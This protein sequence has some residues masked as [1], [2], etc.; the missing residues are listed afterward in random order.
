MSER[1]R[2]RISTSGGT[3]ALPFP[4]QG[5]VENIAYEQQ[6]PLTTTDC[7]NVVPFD[8]SED[9]ARGGQRSGVSKYVT[10]AVN[11]T[12]FIQNITQATKVLPSA[13][14]VPS[15]QVY[16]ETFTGTGGGAIDGGAWV[17][18]R[19]T[20]AAGATWPGIT[21]A[22]DPGVG[23]YLFQ[24]ITNRAA[25]DWTDSVAFV[26]VNEGRLLRKIITPTFPRYP[27]D[28]LHKYILKVRILTDGAAA[29]A[30]GESFYKGIVF[31]HKA[32][33]EEYFFVGWRRDAGANTQTLVLLDSAVVP[34]ITPLTSVVLAGAP[35]SAWH[36]LE[37]RVN[38]NYVEVYWDGE[39]KFI[40]SITP[41]THGTLDHKHFGLVDVR[42]HTAGAWVND[43]IGAFDDFQAFE[44]VP[45]PVFREPKLL[46]VSGG[47]AYEGTP[48][49]I[50]CVLDPVSGGS[51]VFVDD[52]RDIGSQFA[53]QRVFF[54]D[55]T[56]TG[57]RAYT[58]ATNTMVTWASLIAVGGGTLPAP[59]SGTDRCR[60]VSLWKG[61]VILFG[62]VSDPH[63]IF[64]SRIGN[65][66][67][68]NFAATDTS[69]AVQ[70][71]A[72][73][74]GLIADVVT[75]VI[76]YRGDTLLIGGDHSIH[77]L[78]G[79]PG[80]RSVATMQILSDKI[81]IAGPRAWAVSKDRT[82]YFWS[83]DGLYALAP[84]QMNVDRT[85]RLSAGRL[86][87][88]FSDID[89]A[90]NRVT[91]IWDSD[92]HGLFIFI[93]PDEEGPTRHYWFDER[94]SGFF[95]LQFDNPIGPTASIL[96][97]S[98]SP[99][100]R[101]LLMGGF[102]SY[103]RFSDPNA[104]TDDGVLI[105]SRVM[106]GPILSPFKGREL[107]INGLRGVLDES[108]NAVT[109]SVHGGDTAQ[110]AKVAVATFSGT[111]SAGRNNTVHDRAKGAALYVKLSNA[112][113]NT[114]WSIESIEANLREGGP[115]RVR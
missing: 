84:N 13:A 65:P 27:F 22:G 28:D 48:D 79:N 111:W 2:N 55:G 70:L 57:Y 78:M 107:W 101:R 63:N 95:P 60:Y 75:A 82:L 94:T 59:V 1:P 74:V 66:L 73:P 39:R 40:W 62:M 54:A 85:S 108:S 86:D 26:S 88:T 71:S 51:A 47:S 46:V 49:D 21:S 16:N 97:D 8:V 18:R 56:S 53:F 23:A 14:V 100:D 90:V 19:G 87:K 115:V 35:D 80:P 61:R 10:D 104:K 83:S 81:G 24:Y 41:G 91:L 68:W 17:E 106:I 42:M 29:T 50:G 7:L 110:S 67:D 32:G 98:D 38:K 76:P 112:V 96:Y 12:N 36:R 69:A 20:I 114:S 5:M 64:F 11:G 34:V 33:A 102:D 77:A 92:R 43:I 109:Y 15:T 31:R 93:T 30:G 113:L 4:L 72:T 3:T 25:V 9:R 45:P 58:L 99:N 37:L 89:L 52:A 105:N 103:L 6:P 44:A